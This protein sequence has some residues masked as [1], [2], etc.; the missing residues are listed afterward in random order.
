[1][2]YLA[3]ERPLAPPLP[4]NM[5]LLT[6]RVDSTARDSNTYAQRHAYVYSLGSEYTLILKHI[7]LLV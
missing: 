6:Y 4:R 1:M 3:S 7:V 5:V 2:I